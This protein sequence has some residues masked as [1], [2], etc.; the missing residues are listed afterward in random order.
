MKRENM[1]ES[2]LAIKIADIVSSVCTIE[3]VEVLRNEVFRDYLKMV[4]K[5]GRQKS[6][7]EEVKEI[8]GRYDQI[9]KYRPIYDRM[10]NYGSTI[11]TFVLMF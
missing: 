9:E 2:H 5:P 4:L 10:H 8:I 1:F 11:I 7:H 3:D 6:L